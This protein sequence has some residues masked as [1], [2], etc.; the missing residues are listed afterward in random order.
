MKLRVEAGVGVGD[1][2]GLLMEGGNSRR[3][4]VLERLTL[5]CESA[6]SSSRPLS[7]VGSFLENSSLSLIA[8]CSSFTLNNDTLDT[9]V[10]TV[11]ALAFLMMFT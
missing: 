4:D 11:L 2:G 10:A 6:S 9:L 8:N 7:E 5:G 1:G 3:E